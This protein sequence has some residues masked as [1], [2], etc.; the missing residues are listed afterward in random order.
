MPGP[1]IIEEVRSTAG[2]LSLRDEWNTLALERANATVFQTW[3]WN[4]HVWKYS[5][6]K[7][8]KLHILLVR[9]NK[10][11]LTGIAPFY[12]YER[13]ILGVR[14]RIFEFI[15]KNFTDYRDFIIRHDCTTLVHREILVWLSQNKTRWDI[16]DLQYV[17]EES[18]VVKNYSTLFSDFGF[19]TAIQR[20]NICP[21]LSLRRDRDVYENIHSQD[22]VKEIKYKTRRLARDFT[23]RFLSISSSLE[24]EE[25]LGKF[26]ELHRKRR[27][28]KLQRGMFRSEEQEQL[29]TN[30]WS[31]LLGRGLRLCFLLIDNQAAAFLC[32][33]AFKN[34]IYSYQNGLDPRFAKYSLGSIIHSLAIQEALKEG[35]E[36]YDFL[37]GGSDYKREW[38]EQYRTLYRII[39]SR[40]LREPVFTTYEKIL[41]LGR[42]QFRRSKLI[43]KCYV[44]FN[45]ARTR[46]SHMTSTV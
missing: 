43:R 38:T 7:S 25:Y 29:F 1:Y 23:Y 14:F 9:D 33:F 44:W 46:D 24:L 39:I 3:E 2:F 18:D 17:C 31:D 16:V 28:Q 5:E 37:L 12:S 19:R 40:G 45:R 10:G 30:L 34:K 27:D 20:H 11:S 42:R 36:E 4:F 32:N 22:L 15:G 26:F 8:N 6:A 13:S 21:Y 41:G 35:M